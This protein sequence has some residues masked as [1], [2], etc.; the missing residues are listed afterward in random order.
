MIGNFNPWLDDL[1]IKLSS[2]LT[3]VN[4]HDGK[5]EVPELLDDDGIRDDVREPHQEGD[6]D[7][8]R[9]HVTI[10][11]P[12]PSVIKALSP[13]CWHGVRVGHQQAQQPEEGGGQPLA[14]QRGAHHT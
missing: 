4:S 11:T 2:N 3:A 10:V 1:T 13:E 9:E 12:Y 7:A 8:A 6:E 5:L 14:G